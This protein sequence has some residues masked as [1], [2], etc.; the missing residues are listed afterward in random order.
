MPAFLAATRHLRSLGEDGYMP[1]SLASLSWLF[2]LVSIFLLAVGNQDFLV[3][4][5]D[6]MVLVSLGI[7]TLS[8]VWLRRSRGTAYGRSDVLPI[9]VGASCFVAGGAVYLISSSVVVFGTLAILF[10][11]LAFDILELGQLGVQ[12]FLSIL[13]LSCLPLLELFPH[14][15]HAKGGFLSLLPV[16]ATGANDLLLGMLTAAPLIL[17]LN[18]YVDASLLKKTPRHND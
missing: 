13:S 10:A 15:V 5:T 2:T 6:F 16:T 11:Y 1:R 8:A 7:I 17:L 3:E 9:V 12:L 18:L 4:I 14:S